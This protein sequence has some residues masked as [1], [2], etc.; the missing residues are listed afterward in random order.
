VGTALVRGARERE[1]E[2]TPGTTGV[3]EAVARGLFKLTAYKDEYEVARLHLDGVERLRIESEHGRRARVRFHLHPPLLRALGLKRKL[4]L[5]SW[6]VPALRLLRAGRRLRGTPLDPFGAAR[7]RRTERALIGEYREHVAATL[8]GLAPATHATCVELCDLPDL[9]RGY[10]HIKLESVERFR[11]RALELR[12]QLETPVP[13]GQDTPV[14][15]RP[16]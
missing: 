4:V 8:E 14:P 5:G 6:F 11:S 1:D 2:R 7:M 16:Q 13:T 12:A 15:P 9:V 3:A 10:E